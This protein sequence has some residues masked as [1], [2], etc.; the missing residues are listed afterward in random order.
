MPEVTW[1]RKLSLAVIACLIAVVIVLTI[2]LVRLKSRD[3]PPQFDTT[4]QAILLDNGQVYYGRLSRLAT[5]YPEMTD[6]YYI[7]TTQDQ[8]TK[9]VKH[10]LVRRGKEL[11]GPTET[12]FVRRHIVMIE[13]VGPTSEVARLIAQSQAQGK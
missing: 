8:Q 6:V 5:P 2:E 11:H 1:L 9:Q 7:V 12:F 10:V 13:P 3:S 4:F